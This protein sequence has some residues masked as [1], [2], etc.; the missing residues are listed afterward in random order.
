MKFNGVL[1]TFDSAMFWD[2]P[3]DDTDESGANQNNDLTRE[4][5]P[6]RMKLGGTC[7][8]ADEKTMRVLLK[9]R[10][11]HSG[12]LEFYDLRK[13]EWRNIVAYPVADEARASYIDDNGDFV[14]ENF[15]LRF[16][17]MKATKIDL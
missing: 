13:G 6:E 14:F 9:A 1:L 16:V 17:Q 8:Y 4:V 11:K 12:N 2:Y 5:L 10:A 7:L 3:Q 15:E